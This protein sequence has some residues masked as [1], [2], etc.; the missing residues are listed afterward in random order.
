MPISFSLFKK[1]ILKDSTSEKTFD[2]G[3]RYFCNGHVKKIWLE[4]NIL[5]ATVLG[6]YDDYLVKIE[7]DDDHFTYHCTCP[8]EGDCCKHVVAAGLTF[9]QQKGKIVVNSQ[10]VEGEQTNLKEQLLRLSQEDLAD[11]IIL[12]LKT[13][14]HW[15][16]T[17]LKETAKRLEQ[18]GSNVK[19]LYQK[20]FS[21]LLNRITTILEEHNRY[22][23]GEKEEEDKVYEALDDI[24]QLFRENKLDKS[25]KQDFIDK[26]F[27]YYDLGKF[28]NE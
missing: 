18:R 8:Y 4:D 9:L 13:H 22:G 23:G 16:D 7:D 19:N 27:Y 10:K 24:V 3:V 15:K 14:R 21:D 11:L 26:M 12:S 1:Q 28:R 25:L 17:L 20:Q 6:S 2:R 5:Y